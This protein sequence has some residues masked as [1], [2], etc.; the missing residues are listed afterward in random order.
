LFGS[1]V[2]P[3]FDQISIFF[4]VLKLSAVCT[5]WIVLMCW[6]QKWFLKI[7]KNYWHV[8]RHEKLF[9]K[10]PPLHCQTP[11]KAKIKLEKDWKWRQSCTNK[12]SN[13]RIEWTGRIVYLDCFNGAEKWTVKCQI[14]CSDR[15]VFVL[16]YFLN[17]FFYCSWLEHHV[18]HWF[19]LAVFFTTLFFPM[20]SDL[21]WVF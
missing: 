9:E 16:F 12:Q 11:L 1:A 6:C 13:A 2:E 17:C 19:I 20:S 5:F 3:V 10:Q 15:Y 4:F 14:R 8:F 21:S 7:K 18:Q